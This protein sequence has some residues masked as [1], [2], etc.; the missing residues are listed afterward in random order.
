MGQSG[1]EE[2]PGAGARTKAAPE[3]EASTEAQARGCGSRGSRGGG[4]QGEFFL[5]RCRC[6]GL[7]LELRA[8]H[9]QVDGRELRSHEG[10]VEPEGLDRE[11]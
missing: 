5:P 8:V 6:F 4:G 2:G 11:R 10:H 9:V 3:G 7:C 1:Q